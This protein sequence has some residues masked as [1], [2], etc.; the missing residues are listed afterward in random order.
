M[1]KEYESD[2]FLAI[3]EGRLMPKGV[4]SSRTP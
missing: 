2:V 1:R 3:A 4:R